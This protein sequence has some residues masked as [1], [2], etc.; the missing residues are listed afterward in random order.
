VKQA[1]KEEIAERYSWYE[2]SDQEQ[3]NL[4]G[5]L[6]LL[7]A[8]LHGPANLLDLVDV[9]DFSQQQ[10]PGPVQGWAADHSPQGAE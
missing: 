4:M 9:V 8:T 10:P 5:A 3:S 2:L 7:S 1:L 6:N